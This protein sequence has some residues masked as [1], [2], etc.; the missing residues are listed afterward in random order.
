MVRFAELAKEFLIKFDLKKKK[1]SRVDDKESKEV[2]L[3]L[4]FVGLDIKGKV[5]LIIDLN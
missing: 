1:K 4:Q 3:S 5:G 2:T